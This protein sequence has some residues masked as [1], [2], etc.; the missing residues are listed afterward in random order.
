MEA[1][2]CLPYAAI[3]AT[4][5][6]EMSGE[7]RAPEL[8]EVVDEA[9]DSAPWVPVVGLGVFLVLAFI[10][11]WRVFGTEATPAPAEPGAAVAAE[12]AK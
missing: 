9:G 3:S 12:A 11:V 2:C 5:A 6:R 7:K 1:C 10:F 8:P 4:V